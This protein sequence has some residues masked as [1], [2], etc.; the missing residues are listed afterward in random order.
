MSISRRIS[1][2]AV[3]VALTG[4]LAAAK[5]PGEG[6]FVA[7]RV[8]LQISDAAPARQTVLL[9]VAFNVLKAFGPDKVAIE[10][11]AFGPGIDLVRDGNPNAARIRSLVAQGVRFD[12]CNNTIET[13]ERNTGKPFPLNPLAHRVVGGVP[14][15]MFLAEHGYTVIR[16]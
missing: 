14:Q 8:A 9:N 12:A 6:P 10:V 4:G 16:P 3:I 13:I 11:V 5:L 7:H 15:L 2:I 1:L